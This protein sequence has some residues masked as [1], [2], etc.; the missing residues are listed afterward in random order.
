MSGQVKELFNGVWDSAS[1]I[2]SGGMALL[3]AGSLLVVKLEQSWD[4]DEI[5]AMGVGTAVVTVGGGYAV[6]RG[7]G[8]LKQELIRRGYTV[9][10]LVER[11]WPVAEAAEAPLDWFGLVTQ[12]YHPG[13]RK[14]DLPLGV[15]EHGRLVEIKMRGPESHL[16]FSGITGTGK[17]VLVN[18]FIIS[19]AMSGLYQVVIVSLSGK[20]YGTVAQMKNVHLLTYADGLR[21]QE[22]LN[23][24][25]Q[26]LPLVM[27]SFNDE[28]MRRQQFVER[29]EK[30]EMGEV[31]ADVR[32]P[33]VLLVVEEFTNAAEVIRQKSGRK[34]LAEFFGAVTVAAQYGRAS[35]MHLALIGQRPT[36]QVPNNIKKQMVMTSLRVSDAQEA[37]WATGVKDSGAEQLAVV[38][39][40]RGRAGEVAIV[41]SFTRTTAT[42][43]LASDGMLGQAARH[44]EAETRFCGRP[45]WVHGYED[46]SAGQVTLTI[47]LEAVPASSP[48]IEA[49]TIPDTPEA[50]IIEVAAH[51]QPQLV[52]SPQLVVEWITHCYE[53]HEDFAEPPQALSKERVIGIALCLAAEM[54]ENPTMRAVFN[55]LGSRYRGYVKLVKKHV[56][57]L[58]RVIEAR[59]ATK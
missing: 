21:P 18:Q 43:P 36:G 25:V 23:N 32:L 45:T 19:A 59:N 12:T 40:Q 29:Q 1:Y 37:F 15:D 28:V 20:D 14:Y 34:G 39:P 2:A 52:L 8:W 6:V 56:Q 13:R 53:Q 50:E 11:W 9:T 58:T 33:S 16:F 3:G 7:G 27:Q 48:E 54:D 57:T 22:A 17:S 38:D 42:V 44:H 4:L 30:R 46:P 47:P 26:E 55:N 24:F 41:G 10:A 49:H 31:R 51:R 35:N 5:M